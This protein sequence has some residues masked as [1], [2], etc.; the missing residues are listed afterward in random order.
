M[1][2]FTF[3]GYPAQIRSTIGYAKRARDMWWSRRSCVTQ[4]PWCIEKTNEK[5]PSRLNF[6]WLGHWTLNLEV[7][8][9]SQ[10]QTNRQRQ[11][12]PQGNGCFLLLLRCFSLNNVLF[13]K[14]ATS[15]THLWLWWSINEFGVLEMKGKWIPMVKHSRHMNLNQEQSKLHKGISF[16]AFSS[17]LL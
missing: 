13:W 12:R 11:Q 4:A 8:Q 2:K 5:G 15:D 6:Q 16:T 17:Y 14:I 9:K 1:G 3:L 7:F 10:P